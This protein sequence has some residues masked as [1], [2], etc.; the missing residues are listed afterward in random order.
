MQADG[1]VGN[2]RLSWFLECH[3]V[4]TNAQCGFRKHRSAVDHILALDSEVRACFSQRKHLGA[5]FF[6]IQA[7]YDSVPRNGI[8]KKLLIMASVAVWDSSYKAFYLIDTFVS[9]WA[10]T[11]P[12]PSLKRMVSPKVVFSVWRCSL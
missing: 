6:D 3:G 10:T 4:F 1:E 9:E 5:V 8:L 12:A 7:A 2:V 11:F